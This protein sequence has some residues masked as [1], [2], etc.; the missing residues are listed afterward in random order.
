MC[1]SRKQ[2][3]KLEVPAWAVMYGRPI[4]PWKGQRL[5]TLRRVDTLAGRLTRKTSKN[6]MP[7]R[8]FRH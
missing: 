7:Y 8:P 2:H 1:N 4:P 6:E 3:R 5:T